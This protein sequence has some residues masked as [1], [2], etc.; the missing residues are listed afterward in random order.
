MVPAPPWHP[1]ALH[2]SELFAPLAVHTQTLQAHSTWPTFD[3]FNALLDARAVTSEGGARIRCVAQGARPR[4]PNE[5][6]E[7][8]IFLTGEVQTRNANWHDFF[9]L[10]VWLAFPRTKARLNSIHY[11][12][13]QAQPLQTNRSRAQDV[14]TLFDEG[15]I[16]VTSTDATLLELVRQFRWKEL[17][18]Q[19][20]EA[21]LRHLRFFLF[22]HALYEK[23]LAPYK[24]LTAKGLLLD[25]DAT[26]MAQPL[27]VQLA[28]IDTRAADWFATDALQSTRALAPVPILGYPGWDAR[29]ADESYYD[30]SAYFRSGYTRIPRTAKR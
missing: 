5:R 27:A 3:D 28:A 10:M 15:G 7:P 17:F 13:A 11:S 22:G 8:R 6:Y 18:W 2:R 30:D 29:N 20:R 12:L 14:L 24:G 25:V 1:D 4:H 9:N 26:F 23:A 21:V 16:V 19:R